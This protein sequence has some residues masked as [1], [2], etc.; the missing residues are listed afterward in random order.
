[1]ERRQYTN[2]VPDTDRPLISDRL[3]DMRPTLDQVD[4]RK[5]YNSTAI[6]ENKQFHEVGSARIAKEYE[7]D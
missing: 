1:M 4:S 5:N 2:K 7:T 6:D 3:K